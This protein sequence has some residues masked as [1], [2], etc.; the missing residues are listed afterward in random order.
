MIR[1]TR[2]IERNSVILFSS[3]NSFL[4][5]EIAVNIE[6]GFIYNT[7]VRTIPRAKYIYK[8]RLRNLIESSLLFCSLN[9][10]D[11][12][13]STEESIL[14]IRAAINVIVAKQ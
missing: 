4:K 12:G 1:V 10:I 3:N 2:G 8:N 6:I 14:V 5:C 13:T 7:I 9:L 11:S